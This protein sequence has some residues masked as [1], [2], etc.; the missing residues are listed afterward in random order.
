MLSF[1]TSL[2]IFWKENDS[3]IAVYAAYALLACLVISA[4][5]FHNQTSSIPYRRFLIK[6]IALT[7]YNFV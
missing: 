1:E 3:Y 2:A 6:A 7:S 5:E 4:V